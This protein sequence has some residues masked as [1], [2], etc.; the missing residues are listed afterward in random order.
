MHRLLQL[1][2]LMGCFFVAGAQHTLQVKVTNIGASKGN[3]LLALFREANGFPS[4]SKNALVLRELPAKKGTVQFEIGNMA[5]GTYALAVFHDA[6]ADGKLNT[7]LL[8]IP[9]EDYGF[10]NKA[11]PGFRA[12]TFQEAAF[13]ITG[14]SIIEI[15]VK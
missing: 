15:E 12:P 1:F 7:N 6:N 11:R 10:S 9:K 8:G 2:L 13:K 3:I 4:N 5:P 14:T